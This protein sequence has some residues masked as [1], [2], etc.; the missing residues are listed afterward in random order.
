MPDGK[1]RQS[2][3]VIDGNELSNGEKSFDIYQL[4]EHAVALREPKSI[5]AEQFRTLRHSI[6]IHTK[7]QPKK[8]L[9]VTSSVAGEGK[10]LTAVNLAFTLA[11]EEDKKVALVD[12][13]LR[14]AQTHKFL[15]LDPRYGLSDV[16]KDTVHLRIA[17]YPLR[18]EL[19]WGTISNFFFLPAGDI[20]PNPT[21]LLSSKKMQE[22]LQNLRDKY[23][24]I[25]LDCP[26][27]LP[28]A[29][30]KLL[31]ETAD[32]IVFVVRAGK[33]PKDVVTNGIQSLPKPKL[34]GVVFNDVQFA[35]SSYY[36]K[37]YGYYGKEGKQG[38]KS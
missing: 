10:T 19:E 8:L 33:T 36:S 12:C 14:K 4:N 7:D 26:P 15:G 1:T 31:A 9:V 11:M 25:V 28:V 13:D 5:A 23:D 27:V 29:D 34:V 30:A 37:Y 3:K 24:V 2:I 35:W 18:F 17:S 16:L 20:P 22:V 32:G 38:P 6:Q 21:E